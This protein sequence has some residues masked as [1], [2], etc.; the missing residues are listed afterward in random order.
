MTVTLSI[1]V[2]IGLISAAGG[3]AWWAIGIS[4][5]NKL[6][7]QENERLHEYAKNSKP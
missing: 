4:T 1:E 3:F 5:D 6:L 2:I 7:R